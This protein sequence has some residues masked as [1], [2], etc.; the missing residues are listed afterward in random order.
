MQNIPTWEQVAGNSEHKICSFKENDK[1]WQTVSQLFTNVGHRWYQLKLYFE[2]ERRGILWE[3]ERLEVKSQY[4]FWYNLLL[5]TKY[6]AW[7]TFILLE[8]ILSISLAL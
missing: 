5:D 6:L 3:G 8:I 7:D 2:M 4:Y 1:I